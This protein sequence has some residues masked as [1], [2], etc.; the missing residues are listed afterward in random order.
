MRRQ[1]NCWKF[2]TQSLRLH[3]YVLKF[4]KKGTVAGKYPENERGWF[5]NVSNSAR[6]KRDIIKFSFTQVGLW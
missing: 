3:Q 1:R 4:I 2:L 6:N 5:F